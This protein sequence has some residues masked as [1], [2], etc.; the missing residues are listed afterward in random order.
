VLDRG[1]LAKDFHRYRSTK[2]SVT[3]YFDYVLWFTSSVKASG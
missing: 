3:V 1:R 2:F